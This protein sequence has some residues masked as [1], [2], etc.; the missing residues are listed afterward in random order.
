VAKDDGKSFEGH[1]AMKARMGRNTC[2]SL[3]VMARSGMWP[4]PRAQ[5]GPKM[6]AN[7]G[8]GA[9]AHI[10]SGR[11]NL[12]EYVQMWPIPASRDYRHPNA[13]SYEERGGGTKGEQLPNAVG[14]AL[15]PTWVCALMG[16][17]PGWLDLAEDKVSR[18]G[19]RTGK[20]ASR[21]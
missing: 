20:T 11:G 17:P 14:G 8:P 12:A 7:L 4:T 3:A 19:D 18:R 21:E 6:A 13:Q 1:M 16:L 5:D 15:N 10:E 9:L 2:S